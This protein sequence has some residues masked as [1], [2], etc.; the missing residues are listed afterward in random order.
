MAAT[1]ARP[2]PR[3]PTPGSPSVATRCR[4]AIER[5]AAKLWRQGTTERA[6]PYRRRRWWQK[7]NVGRGARTPYGCPACSGT[8]HNWRPPAMRHCAARSE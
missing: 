3:R 8:L 2:S 6:A 5:G 1:R 7:Q 4:N